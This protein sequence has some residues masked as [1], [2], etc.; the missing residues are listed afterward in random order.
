[1]TETPFYTPVTDK[2][3]LEIW[4]INLKAY[5][6]S[7]LLIKFLLIFT[8]VLHCPSFESKLRDGAM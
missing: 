5:A 1:M 7:N 8:D 4:A 2:K 6:I 3:L